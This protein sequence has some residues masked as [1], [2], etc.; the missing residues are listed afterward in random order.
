M[1]RGV[2]GLEPAWL[3]AP[4]VLIASGDGTENTTAPPADPGWS[5]VGSVNGLSGVYLGDGWVRSV[6]MTSTEGLKRSM[7][8]T[9]TGAPITVPVGE[10][11][12]GWLALKKPSTD[13]KVKRGKRRLADSSVQ[14][15]W[16]GI[17]V[18]TGEH[19]IALPSGEAI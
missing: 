11:V 18:R 17:N 6:A 12:L 3:F 19:V 9:D 10:E 13:R 14:G 4:A 15:T 16:S 8:V 1:V 7:P 5:H 2:L